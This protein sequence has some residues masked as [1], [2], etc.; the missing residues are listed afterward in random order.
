[1]NLYPPGVW[2]AGVMLSFSGVTFFVSNALFRFRFRR[3]AFSMNP[4]PFVLSFFD[5]H[6]PEQPLTVI[7]NNF[8]HSF[9][10][11]LELSFFP[12]I[13]GAIALFSL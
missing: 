1:M 13:F 5:I 12:S 6:A 8:R 9:F 4:R 7:T 3:D 10:V 11:S 2:F